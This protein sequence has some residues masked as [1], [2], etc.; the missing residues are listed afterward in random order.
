MSK[1]KIISIVNQKGGVAKTTT[2]FNLSTSLARQGKKVLIVDLDPQADL[3]MCMGIIKPDSLEYTIANVFDD[4]IRDTESLDISK[5]IQTSEDVDLVPSSI[6]LAGVERILPNTD[7]K[8]YGLKS[9]LSNYV[10]DYDYILIDCMPSLGDLTVNALTASDCVLIPVQAHFLSAKGLEQLVA[11]I[12]RV[13]KRLNPT[14]SIMGIVI[15][16]VNERLKFTKAILKEM[17]DVYGKHIN[18]YATMIPH[19][20]KAVEHTATGQSIYKFDPKCKVSIAYEE[21]AMEVL[22]NG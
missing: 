10:N 18:I 2:T 7:A 3:T 4:Y 9:F 15:T 12:A 11:S 5:L 1:A 16:M 14:L 21:F 13:R 17:N 8:E 22:N 19:S 6:L 20:T